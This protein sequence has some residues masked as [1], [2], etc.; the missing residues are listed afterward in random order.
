MRERIIY[1]RDDGQDFTAFV[2][3]SDNV[4][5]HAQPFQGWVWRGFR[6]LQKRICLGALLR[7]QK[8]GQKPLTL[9]YPVV[10]VGKYRKA[11]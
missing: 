9:R 10:A 6:I 11:A 3:G 5:V 4:I 7:I 2:V 1:L 8:P